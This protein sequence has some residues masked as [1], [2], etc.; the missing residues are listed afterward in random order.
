M[1]L[2][3]SALEFVHAGFVFG[4]ELSAL[5]FM[6]GF[7]LGTQLRLRLLHFSLVLAAQLFAYLD[8]E[9]LSLLLDAFET[10]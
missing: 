4:G 7:K 5:S 9:L 6:L 2:I 3:S 10:T 1:K 8:F